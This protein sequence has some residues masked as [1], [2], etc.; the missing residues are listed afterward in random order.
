MKISMGDAI[1]ADGVIIKGSV[2][3]DESTL[4][5][6][7]IPVERSVGD[8]VYA[9][10]TAVRGEV[11][12]KV[13]AT[14]VRT[15]FG[16]TIE[17]IQVAK[18]RLLIEE[19]TN[20]ITKWLLL[21]DSLFIVLVVVKLVSAGIDVLDILPFTLTLLLASIPIAL[22]AMTTIT[23]ALGS[24]ELAKSGVI[25]R[26]L[27]A[28]EA[29]SM[30]DVICLD[31][32]GTI[33]ENKVVVSRIIPLSS[34][35]SERDLILLAALASEEVTKDPIDNA[36]RLK[37]RELK[38]DLSIAEILEFRPFT[39]ETKSS[40][41]L[42][43]LQESKLRVIKGAPQVLLQLTGNDSRKGVER[44]V[45]ELSR[46][47]FRSLAIAIEDQQSNV[48][49]IG[50][51]GLYDRPR[52][53]SKRFIDII[54]GFGVMPKMITGDNIHIAKAIAFRNCFR[55]HEG[56]YQLVSLLCYDYCVYFFTM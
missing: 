19:I 9:G 53:D 26:K 11:I 44:I 28:I 38:I 51:L 47:G 7:S 21:I 30:M 39:P 55:F 13:T 35:F 4:T 17:L 1:P 36:I 34:K 8:G 54:R 31:K 42:I 52:E 46:E 43:K 10:T 48:E 24:V 37:A 5:G 20:S 14:G 25:I 3:V 23:L 40:E 56:L 15:R 41:A 29:A 33:T 50:V 49:I 32:T 2:I 45:E 16:R 6:E 22:P 27:E 12:I 18:P